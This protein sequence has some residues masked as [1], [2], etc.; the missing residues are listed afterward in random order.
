MQ[1][2]TNARIA[3][4]LKASVVLL[5]RVA[6]AMRVSCRPAGLCQGILLQGMQVAVA[7]G[8]ARLLS[9]YCRW[10]C[11]AARSVDAESAQKPRPGLI[12]SDIDILVSLGFASFVKN[13]PERELG[14]PEKDR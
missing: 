13:G 14:Q 10:L 2:T 6:I 8:V 3:C 12:A 1:T 4:I 5:Q 7:R 9:G 11:M